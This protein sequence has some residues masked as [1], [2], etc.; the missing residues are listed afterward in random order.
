M[1][2]SLV[3]LLLAAAVLLGG[4]GGDDAGSEEP[5]AELAVPWVDPDGDPPYIGS[6]SVNPRDGTLL[7][8][9]NTGL[10]SIPKAG[11]KPTKVTGRLTT[12]NGEGT[13]SESLVAEF[14]GP[15]QLI[16][17]GHPSGD[18]T[19]PPALGLIRSGDAGRTWESVS[20]LGTADFHALSNSGDL[21]VAPIYGQAQILLSRDAGK[22]FEP[23]VAPMA[24]V[25]LAADPGDP[26]RWAATSESG[27][28]VSV[29][30]GR[31]WRQRDPTPNVR[32]AWRAP[33]ELYRI[34][35]GGP[36]K[37]SADGG[38]T[39]QDRGDTGGEPQAL[40]AG[41]DGALYA[42]TLDGKVQK[43]AD[44]GRSWT[45]LVTP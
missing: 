25:D 21:L 18:S 4:C 13:I 34:D 29:D 17:S 7:M 23:R 43:S 22:T 6:L 42:A 15:D 38:E 12:P 9:T 2:P 11:G 39:W 1:R 32:L 30:E 45:A 40:A 16:A 37:V 41:P 5:A 36:V 33:G 19:L 26:K 35:P 8:G 24:L 28:F 20:E 27:I 31:T 3:F 14:T 44:G 10:F